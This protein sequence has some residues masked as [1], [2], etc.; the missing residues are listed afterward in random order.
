MRDRYERVCESQ[1]ICASMH[2]VRSTVNAQLQGPPY[3]LNPLCMC[4]WSARLV[5]VSHMRISCVCV[6]VHASC[7]CLMYMWYV[8]VDVIS[9][10]L[11]HVSVC[12]HPTFHR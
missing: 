8:H 3:V 11:M 4:T 2:A 5:C 10:R 9:A 12:V 6:C 1:D 7:A